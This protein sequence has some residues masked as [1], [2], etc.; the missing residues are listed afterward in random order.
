M[1]PNMDGYQLCRRIKTNIKTNHIPVILLTA[2]ASIENKIEGLE[3]GADDYLVK[4]FNTD[5]LS[6]SKKSY[7]YKKTDE[8]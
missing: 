1:M 7:P 3:T 4:P 5:E 8:R 6:K 2:K